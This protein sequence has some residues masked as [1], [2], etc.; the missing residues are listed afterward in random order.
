[1]SPS[2]ILK[3]MTLGE[4]IFC[5]AAQKP[6]HYYKSWIKPDLAPWVG[7]LGLL[8]LSGW[9]ARFLHLLWSSVELDLILPIQ[10]HLSAKRE[11]DTERE[12][13][14][15]RK[16]VLVSCLLGSYSV[17]ATTLSR[18]R[19]LSYLILTPEEGIFNHSHL[20]M[21]ELKLSINDL[22]KVAYLVLTGACIWNQDGLTPEPM[23]FTMT[24]LDC[25]LPKD[26]AGSERMRTIHG[27]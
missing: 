21:T 17:L 7:S 22:P 13:Q 18:L 4:L 11:R 8:C 27:S 14:R 20:Q 24:L 16:G 5:T 6:E 9:K 1:M 19:V 2:S 10:P 15:K 26:T 12:R 3:G 23:P 25:H